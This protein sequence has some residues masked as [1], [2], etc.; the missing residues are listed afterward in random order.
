LRKD[1]TVPV[2]AFSTKDNRI[3]YPSGDFETFVT[4]EELEAAGLGNDPPVSF[5]VLDSCQFI[6]ERNCGH[7]FKR[8]I[9]QQYYKHLE[10]KA[11]GDSLEHAIKVV[12]NSIYG[13]TVQRVNNRMGNIFNPLLHHTSPLYK[14][15]ALSLRR[16]KL[17]RAGCHHLCDRLARHH[18]GNTKFEH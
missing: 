6:P 3:I 15:A 1:R 10:L 9:E 12:L 2:Q 5:R 16:R 13:K 11:K 4:L 17:T 14:G 7:P 8:F 18:P